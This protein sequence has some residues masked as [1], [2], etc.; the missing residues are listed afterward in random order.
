[1]MEVTPLYIGSQSGPNSHA[2]PKPGQISILPGSDET[3][4]IVTVSPSDEFFALIVAVSFHCS[5]NRNLIDMTMSKG[6]AKPSAKRGFN[7]MM[8]VLIVF[9]E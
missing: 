8:K 9:G 1:M 3:R 7:F 5:G 6:Q 2:L 4:L